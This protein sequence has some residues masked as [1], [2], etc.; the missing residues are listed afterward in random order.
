[1]LSRA[2]ALNERMPICHYNIGFAYGQLGDRREAARHYR[3][4]VELRPS[5]AQALTN[6][7]VV[8]T[9]EGEMQAAFES[10]AR[11]LAIQEL[12]EAKLL[13]AQLL[14]L[15]PGAPIGRHAILARV[16][17]E[18]W[19]RPTELAGACSLAIKS[20]PKVANLIGRVAGAWPQRPSLPDLIN[21]PDIVAIEEH[22]LLRVA[23]ESAP[24]CDLELERFLTVFRWVLLQAATASTESLPLFDKA[25]RFFCALARQCFINGYIFSLTEA[26]IAA[27][28]HLRS[29]LEAALGSGSEY[30]AA[31]PIAVA[32][33]GPLHALAHS[34][35]LFNRRFENP[36]GAVLNQQIRE[37]LEDQRLAASI[38]AITVVKDETSRQ[39]QRQYEE[40]PYPCWVTG[41]AAR[42][43]KPLAHEI[44]S[45]VPDSTFRP[46]R[47]VEHPELLIAGCGTGQALVDVARAVLGARVLAIDLS[48][49]SLGYAKRKAAEAGLSAIEFGQADI[50]ELG[51]IGRRFDFIDCSG[52]LHHLRDPWAGWRA[53]LP[54]LHPDGIMRIGLYSK[55]A[56]RLINAV[57]QFAVDRGYGANADDIRRCRQELVATGDKV[58]V[59][60][61]AASSDFYAT[62][63][64][65]DLLFH[66]QEHQMTIPEIK[67]FL[68]DH[69]LQFVGFD[70]DA[71]A[72]H[73]FRTRFPGPQAMNDLDCWHEFETEQPATFLG[74]YQFV[75]QPRA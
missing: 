42:A 49:A 24:I 11:A 59:D 70:V 60:S 19:T 50:M 64:C 5:Y 62:S 53:L 57:R 61:V 14:Q 40:H 35:E 21:G 65:R 4:A 47:A 18:A 12:P 22:E 33:Y 17:R 73:R 30:P 9:A 56:R 26:E 36:V 7:A 2:L 15:V 46:P 1:M 25:T 37:P 74:M 23:L 52:V 39:V 41:A 69:D 31:W 29:A 45:W 55:R 66:V 72:L 34:Q 32:A 67:S 68:M 27:V 8:L 10:V 54:L 38:T 44:R 58:M 48:R 28:Q 75:V 16:M 43:P 13:Y 6:L 20:D 63:S 3:R 51:S 71:A